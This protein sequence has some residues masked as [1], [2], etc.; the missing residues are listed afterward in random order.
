MGSG[1]RLSLL[2][3]G[4][5]GRRRQRT[6]AHCQNYI[7]RPTAG[8]WATK[9]IISC[10]RRRYMGLLP[11]SSAQRPRT[12]NNRVKPDALETDAPPSLALEEAGSRRCGCP[13]MMEQG[14]K[15][16]FSKPNSPRAAEIPPRPAITAITVTR[17]SLP[18]NVHP[19]ALTGVGNVETNL[20]LTDLSP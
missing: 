5:P 11:T 12:N 1:K 6:I 7:I 15:R 17:P 2:P 10:R 14:G 18:I 8:E 3:A 20:E 9:Q 19:A 13:T 4:Q 16:K